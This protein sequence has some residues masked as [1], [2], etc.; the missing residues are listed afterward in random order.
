[1][2]EEKVSMPVALRGAQE[3]LAKGQYQEVVKLCK[4]VL[5]QDRNSYDAYVLLGSALFQLRQYVPAEKALR[6]AVGVNAS[7]MAAWQ[8]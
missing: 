7:K 4:I 3:S 8:V 6:L 1:M 2:A 5:K